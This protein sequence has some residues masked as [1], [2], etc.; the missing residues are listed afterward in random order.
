MGS[1]GRRR[2]IGVSDA[3]GVPAP[4]VDPVVSAE[5]ARV[6]TA[7]SGRLIRLATLLVGPG[8]APDV[9]MEAVARAVR[10]ATW[11]AIADHRSYLTRTLVNLAHDRHRQTDRRRRREDKV[12][13]LTAT[14]TERNA[15]DAIR[16]RTA[17]RSLPPVQLAVI[18]LRFWE[19]LTTARIAEVLDISEGSVVQHLHRAKRRLRPVLEDES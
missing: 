2:L 10:A 15:I 5:W 14:P 16:V 17:I 13:R 1:P 3:V 6:Y 11:S 18:Y 7:E 9:V 19:D 8:D 12:A 4:A